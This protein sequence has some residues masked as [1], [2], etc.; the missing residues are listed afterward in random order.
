MMEAEIIPHGSSYK[1]NRSATNEGVT[2]TQ[3]FTPRQYQ[4]ELLDAALDHNS[5]ICLQ[6]DTSKTFIAVMLMKELSKALRLPLQEGGKR[7]MY[8]VNDVS[9]VLQQASVI[10][11]HTDLSIG[12]F[13]SCSSVDD[14]FSVAEWKQKFVLCQVIITTAKVFLKVLEARLVCPSQL[15]LLIFDECHLATDKHPYC[16]ITRTLSERTDLSCLPR[17]MGMTASILHSKCEPETLEKKLK[18]LEQTLKSVV[19]TYSSGCLTRF[20]AKPKEAIVACKVEEGFKNISKLVHNVLNESLLFMQECSVQYNAVEGDPLM[21][22]ERA[23]REC[24]M[25]FEAIGPLGLRIMV[26]MLLKKLQRIEKRASNSLSKLILHYGCTQ[27]RLARKICESSIVELEDPLDLR[28]TTP[29]VRRLLEVLKEFQPSEESEAGFE[30]Q[31]TVRRPNRTLGGGILHKMHNE[32]LTSNRL[33]PVYSYDDEE[34]SNS[35]DEDHDKEENTDAQGETN[36][37]GIVLVNR[38]FLALVLDKLVHKLQRKDPVL[39]FI[40]S[41][42]IVGH[43]QGGVEVLGVTKEQ[44]FKKQEEILR[45]FRRHE[46]NLLFATSALEEGVDVPRCNLVIRF[47]VPD[48]YRS[49]VLSKGRARAPNSHYIML[50]EEANLEPFTRELGNFQEIDKILQRKCHHREQQCWDETDLQEADSLCAPYRPNKAEDAGMVTMTTAISLVNRYCSKLPS[51]TFTHLSPKCHTAPMHTGTGPVMYQSQIF[52]PINSPIRDPIQGPPMPKRKLAEMAAALKTC[53]TL[54]KA[55]ELDDNLLPV[56]KD[57]VLL[58]EDFGYEQE[59]VEEGQGRPGTTKRRQYYNK[60]VAMCLK[61]CHP[62]I[63][64]PCH[65]YE[66]HMSLA[67]P[68]PEVL[69]VRDRKLHVPEETTQCF[70]ILTTKII[71]KI[72]GF[73]VYTRAGELVISVDLLTS[74]ITVTSDQLNQLQRFHSCIFAEVLRLEK[75]NLEFDTEKAE[76]NY[77]IAPLNKS[78]EDQKLHIDWNFLKT[79]SESSG[80][81]DRPPILPDYS[82]NQFVFS[83]EAFADAVVTPIYRNIDQPQRYYIAD[84]LNNLPVTSPFP[85][86]KYEKFIDYYFER[87]DIQLS[88]Y[89]QPLLDVDCMSSRL[90]LLTPRYLNHKGKALPISKTQSKKNYLQKKQYLVPELCYIY[91][92]PASLWRKAVCLPSILYRLNSLLVAEELRVQ[93]SMGAGVG[94]AELPPD[95]YPFANMTFGWEGLELQNLENQNKQP[96]EAKDGSTVERTGG[97]PKGTETKQEKNENSKLKERTS[98]CLDTESL[99][100]A[101]NITLLKKMNG[102]VKGQKYLDH[103]TVGLNSKTVT[104]TEQ[105]AIAK[106][107]CSREGHNDGFKSTIPPELNSSNLEKTDK[108]KVNLKSEGA[109]VRHHKLEVSP[110]SSREKMACASSPSEGYCRCLQERNQ[111]EFDEASRGRGGY[112]LKLSVLDDQGHDPASLP[113]PS[114][115]TILQSLTMSNSSD[116]FNLE[117]LEM[118]GD[119]FLKQAVTIY[120]YCTYPRRHEGKLSYMRSKQ[121]SNFNL[122]RLGKGKAI[123]QKMQVALFDPA[124]NWLAPCFS[125]KENAPTEEQP[126]YKSYQ[127]EGSDLSSDDGD[128]AIDTWDPSSVDMWDS[129]A[130][131]EE[132]TAPD[133]EIPMMT[134]EDMDSDFSDEDPTYQY[135]DR[136][137]RSLDPWTFSLEDADNLPGLTYTGR[138]PDDMGDLPELPYEIHTQHNLS[139]K[140]LADSVEALIGCYLISCG[141]RSALIVM[142]WFGLRVLPQICEGAPCDSEAKVVDELVTW[143]QEYSENQ[144]NCKKP[145]ARYGYLK[146]PE[147]PFF[148]NVSDAEERLNHLLVGM[149][150]FEQTIKYSF[151]DKAYLVQAF[152][153]ASYHYNC[154]T[155]CYQRLEFLG[156]AILDY[157]ITRHLFDHHQDLSP[158]ALTDL[159][160]A[161]VNNTI[162]A[163]LAVKFGY[164]KYFKA[165]SPELFHVID[166]FVT[167]VKEK[168]EALGMGS[169]LKVLDVEG[170]PGH[171]DESEDIEVPKALGDIFESVAGAVYL[172]SGMSLD[173]VWRVYYPLMKPQIEQY[174]ASLPISPVRELLEM[175]PETARFGPPERTMDGKTRV[176][177]NVVGKGKFKGIGRNYRI[178]KATA[179]RCA[180]RHLKSQKK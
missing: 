59:V 119:S 167:F 64:Q 109:L 47:D 7:M 98:C 162:F 176:T 46:I 44:Q 31:E 67:S 105:D 157:L 37:Y 69:N 53:E 142:S 137:F 100:E 77:L 116:G 76:A 161:L 56:G 60:E 111:N 126:S 78:D 14:H 123:G 148:R 15:N 120:L 175:E 133:F 49:Y 171:E 135:P 173:T 131:I 146:Q 129:N 89:Q 61:S 118:L 41:S 128:F 52:L 19:E 29:K 27:L 179:A 93:I 79:V 8:L 108:A 141:F 156:D 62:S 16:E 68:L 39:A 102:E 35:D 166:N 54:H 58:L 130:V 92:I 71:P 55:G 154:V 17:I 80:M 94:V 125:V 106:E 66:I 48:H 72:P 136:S 180:L 95:V 1:I 140:N 73:P 110:A 2:A 38:H 177:V 138:K 75:P 43:H 86:E 20:C 121:V 172:D 45:R 26:P 70:G 51:D 10:R 6:T 13:I 112:T 24:L 168:K 104:G 107:M 169:Q 88:N 103:S 42:C 147:S 57:T 12:E 145:Q 164:H 50:V 25:T 163:S 178:A 65:L 9:T 101:G 36:M 3:T 97:S 115:T 74:D 30:I 99:G 117:R 114:P 143:E 83:H 139:D 160:S 170:L 151:S 40:N 122:Y 34:E 22:V 96:G 124:I 155:D 82:R 33:H 174:A 113:G 153:H 28:L 32:R 81:L 91:P 4:V 5:V 144:N 23:I 90:N 11:E 21:P 134:K 18:A 85:S 165:L 150:D 63:N 159:R 152:T 132:E 158:G 127:K 87:Y 149:D 84:I